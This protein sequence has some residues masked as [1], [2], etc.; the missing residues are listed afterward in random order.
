VVPL[1][2]YPTGV[3]PLLNLLPTGALAEGLREALAGATIGVGHVAVLLAWALGAGAL[4][5]R[6]FRW[7]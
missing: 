5:A 6:T 1:H 7:E 2:R 3:Q 4:T